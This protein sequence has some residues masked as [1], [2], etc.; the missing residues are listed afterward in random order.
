MK[1]NLKLTLFQALEMQ[2]YFGERNESCSLTYTCQYLHKW[3]FLSLV[4]WAFLPLGNWQKA[5]EI[6]VLL[7]LNSFLSA[8]LGIL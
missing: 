2:E 1:P 6:L 8:F 4:V 7:R 5:M 3:L